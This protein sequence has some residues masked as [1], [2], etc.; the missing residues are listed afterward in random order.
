MFWRAGLTIKFLSRFI[1]RKG[2]AHASGPPFTFSLPPQECQSMNDSE[3][4]GFS[5]QP[6][7]AGDF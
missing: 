5:A 4:L 2:S 1:L 7:K 6:T 3:M